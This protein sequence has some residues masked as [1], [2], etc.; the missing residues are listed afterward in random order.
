MLDKNG[1][2]KAVNAQL[3]KFEPIQ[4]RNIVG[5][6]FGEALQLSNINGLEKELYKT[7]NEKLEKYHN[8]Y[9]VVFNSN[10]EISLDCINDYIIVVI[11]CQK[12][13][14]QIINE[15]DTQNTLKP[16]LEYVPAAIVMFDNFMQIISASDNWLERYGFKITDVL[17]KSYYDLFAEVTDHWKAI[18]DKC[19][20]GAVEKNECDV[21]PIRKN[22][23]DYVKWEI[24]PWRRLNGSIGGVI[25]FSEIIT[26]IEKKRKALQR[27]YR[28]LNLLT[29]VGEIVIYAQDDF[30]M[31]ENVCK[32]II[33][34]GNYQLV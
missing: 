23:L 12:C 7:I 19:L 6:P 4:N 24:R 11:I 25:M 34:V 26:E 13:S 9:S 27:L 16:L 30:E 14:A 22:Q 18:F 3:S 28:E 2:I 20:A 1:I 10:L 17:G 15:A 21:L 8:D 29:T 33:N 32:A 5:E 31:I